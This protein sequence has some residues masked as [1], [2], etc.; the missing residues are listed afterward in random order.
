MMSATKILKKRLANMTLLDMEKAT[1]ELETRR[2][3]EGNPMIRSSY[4]SQLSILALAIAKRKNG[5]A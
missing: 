4:T 2:A 1:A 5:K 3:G